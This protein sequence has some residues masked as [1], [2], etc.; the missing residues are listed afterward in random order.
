MPLALRVGSRTLQGPHRGDNEDAV[1]VLEAPDRVA[2]VVA[3]GRGGQGLGALASQR[4]VAAILAALAGDPFAL[5][6][7]IARAH[8]DVLTLS[9]D[10]CQAISTVTV[11]LWPRGAGVI[12]LAHLGD[13]RA[14]RARGD[15][16]QQLTQDHDAIGA[17]AA[18]Y[19]AS[20]EDVLSRWHV[21]N[22]LVRYLGNKAGN[23]EPDLSAVSV[24]PGDRLLLC[25]D[26]L[27]NF[28]KDGELL[29]LLSA[30]FDTQKCA[31][32][33]AQLALDRRS[34]DNVSCIVGQFF[35]EEGP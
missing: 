29:G 15:A 7:A 19:G 22:V 13:T 17:L 34:R 10:I 30:R 6:A 33:L 32:A 2:C 8:E 18:H 28:V 1:A 11:A 35:E 12:H 25:T 20:R 16:L 14:Y 23:A 21:R 4:A 31:D 27:S 24:Q 26:G 3:D 9:Q 5:R